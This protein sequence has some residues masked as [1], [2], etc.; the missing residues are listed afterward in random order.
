MQLRESSRPELGDLVGRGSVVPGACELASWSVNGAVVNVRWRDAAL[1]QGLACE[2]EPYDPRGLTLHRLSESLQATLLL[3]MQF[4]ELWLAL[5]SAQHWTTLRPS[6]AA[7]FRRLAA[8]GID[9]VF[10]REPLAG[11]QERAGDFRRLAELA[12]AARALG[13]MHDRPDP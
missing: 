8:A 12:A 11:D 2:A 3:P 4:R 7:H 13:A 6:L 9:R 5:E 1:L 10:E